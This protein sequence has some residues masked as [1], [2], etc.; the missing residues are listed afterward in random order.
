[1]S[2]KIFALFVLS[3]L[4]FILSPK[5]DA[6]K[7]LPPLQMS[8]FQIDLAEEKVEI[9]LRARANIDSRKVS[10]SISLPLGLSLIDGD[11]KWE[12]LL[13]KGETKSVKLVIQNLRGFSQ[14]ITSVATVFLKSGETYVQRNRLI[15]NPSPREVPI[16]PP[17]ILGKEGGK[18]ILQFKGK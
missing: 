17:P 10:L 11:E 5:A 4:V 18:P 7:P 3:L 12:G 2:R 9:T 15:L 6:E 16:P 14:E 13:K 1:M 8:L